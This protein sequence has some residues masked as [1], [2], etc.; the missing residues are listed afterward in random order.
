MDEGGEDKGPTVIEGYAALYGARTVIWG[1]F[2][3]EIVEGFFAPA[4]RDKHD[5]RSLFNHDANF[6]LGRTKSGTLVLRDDSKGLWTETKTPDSPIACSIV[7][8]IRRGDVDGMSFAFTI[9]RQEWIFAEEGSGAMDLRRLLEIEKLYDVGP[10]TYPAYEQTSIKIREE[11]RKRYEEARARWQER[12]RT[13][14]IAVPDGLTGFLCEARSAQG[15]WVA[16]DLVKRIDEE[17]KV[18]DEQEKTTEEVVPEAP[19]T[20]SEPP[21]ATEGQT[22][23]EGEGSGE[24]EP[25]KCEEEKSRGRDPNAVIREVSACQARLRFYARHP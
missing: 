13:I 17:A 1:W 7:E 12:N 18:I 3:E 20:Q 25:V 8:S 2:E 14:Q 22:A 5:C 11:D 4:I 19:A 10:V 23:P 16:E 6:P 24:G 9:H 15:L 21:K